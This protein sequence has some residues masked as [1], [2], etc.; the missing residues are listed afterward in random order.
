M[1]V[2]RQP[3]LHL[4]AP[5]VATRLPPIRRA[6]TAWAR[7]QGMSDD[8]AADLALASYEAMTNVVIHAYGA[9]GGDI[10]VL[11]VRPDGHVTVTITDHG[12]WRAR[13]NATSGREGGG[14]GLAMIRLLAHA[15][16][17]VRGPQGTAVRM[18]WNL[19]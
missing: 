3:E 2:A 16:D 8:D 11:A 6:L 14:R 10:D 1:R 15:V 4:A 5:A 12:S 13:P 19:T 18:S 7:D 17:I 9:S